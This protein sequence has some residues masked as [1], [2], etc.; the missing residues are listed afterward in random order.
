MVIAVGMVVGA[1][2]LQIHNDLVDKKAKENSEKVI[3]EIEKIFD[4]YLEEDMAGIETQ[5]PDTI[6]IDGTDYIG[7]LYF[8]RLDNL[9]LPVIKDYSDTNLKISIC[10]YHGSVEQND[11]VICGHNY[12]YSF[13]K[14]SSLQLGSIVY[15]KSMAGDVYKYKCSKIEQLSP[16]E[17][18][19]MITRDSWDSTL[20]T[21]SYGKQKRVTY[22]FELVNEV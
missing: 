9:E 12:K 19:K 17:V 6:N 3:T 18:D 11:M 1:G 5:R 20:F 4:K 22:R 16:D 14:L 7:T 15:Y 2:T 21:C 10:R 8:P 13:G